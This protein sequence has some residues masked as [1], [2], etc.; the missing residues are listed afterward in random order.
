[1]K[2]EI[3]INFL[4]WSLA[5]LLYSIAKHV[6]IPAYKLRVAMTPTTKSNCELCERENRNAAFIFSATRFLTKIASI[7]FIG[8]LANYG[9][10]A[11]ASFHFAK[12]LKKGEVW[13]TKNQN[14]RNAIQN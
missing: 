7:P 5:Y 1:M 6:A 10:A 12:T 13:L 8:K 2:H 11:I 9:I 3:L 14:A 4:G